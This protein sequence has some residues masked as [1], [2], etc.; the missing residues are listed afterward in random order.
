[1]N[2]LNEYIFPKINKICDNNELYLTLRFDIQYTIFAMIYSTSFGHCAK[3][4]L[5]NNKITKQFLK[6]NHYQNN[7]ALLLG[8]FV[9]MIIPNLKIANFFN[10]YVFNTFNTTDQLD[11][12][13]SKW[14]DN[15]EK[16]VYLPNKK[17]QQQKPSNNNNDNNDNINITKNNSEYYIDEMLNQVYNNKL[18]KQEMMRDVLSLFSAGID[19]TAT[20]FELG[21][22]YL[23]KY[24]NIQDDIYNELIEYVKKYNKFNLDHRTDLHILRAFV[25][26]LLRNIKHAAVSFPRYVDFDGLIIGGT[27]IPKGFY[28]SANHYYI[29]H[30]SKYW[31]KPNQFYIKHFLN[32]SNKFK[33]NSK[34]F[35]TFGRAKR[36]CI[37]QTIAIKFLEIL[38]GHFILKYKFY[39]KNNDLKS[40][41]IPTQWVNAHVKETPILVKTRN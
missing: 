18:T 39:P 6:C 27:N 19:T 4:P 7:I 14:I 41:K 10:H 8:L 22:L 23:I 24:P 34:Y 30:C 15:Y 31:Q 9:G 13:V 28:V 29:N 5:Q 11:K 2:I 17:Q 25:Q 20:T 21:I 16:Q 35:M 1:M 33:A 32:E 38:F 3:L 36:E 40:F 12:I 26:E 37:G